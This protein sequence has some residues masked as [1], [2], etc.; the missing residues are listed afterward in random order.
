MIDDEKKAKRRIVG[1]ALMGSAFLM[2]AVAMLIY[3]GS[4][5]LSEQ[6]RSLVL[7]LLGL[8]A[9]TDLAM[10]AYFIISNPS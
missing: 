7:G 6:A 2:L 9:V 8:V 1:F 10:A 4:I 3:A 5:E